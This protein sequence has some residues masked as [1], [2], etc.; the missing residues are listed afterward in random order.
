MSNI[1]TKVNLRQL[2]SEVRKFSSKK[3]GEIECLVIPIKQNNLFEGEK[4][5]YLDI[6]AIEIKNKVNNS[7]DTHLLKQDLPKE[8][9]SKM[10]DD[11][12][13][14]MPILGNAIYWGKREAEPVPP[15]EELSAEEKDDL[16]F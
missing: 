8:V 15:D 4:G 7:K 1:S 14:A 10:S 13:K 12:K 16:P 9:Y 5:V 6:S 2:K 3:S 11:E